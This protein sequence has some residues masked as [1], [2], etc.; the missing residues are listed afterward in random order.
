MELQYSNNY[1]TGIQ[2]PHAAALPAAA[3]RY[4][5]QTGKTGSREAIVNALN[6]ADEASK[7]IKEKNEILKIQL[8]Q[9]E[10]IAD[11]SRGFI[12][13]GDTNL[14]LKDAIA[15]L[16]Q[17][18]KVTQVT[19]YSIEYQ[20]E[21]ISSAYHWSQSDTMPCLARQELLAMVKYYFPE[22]LPA[23]GILPMI[24]CSDI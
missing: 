11:I 2:L 7:S 16:G 17:Y 8:K 13:P 15:K 20:H 22:I 6:E 4:F 19:V 12:A 18:H 23:S 3:R 5:N 1:F 9:Q 24:S 14:H 21:K 10:L